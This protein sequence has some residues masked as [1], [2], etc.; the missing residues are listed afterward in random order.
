M[1]NGN[2]V[3]CN[4]KQTEILNRTTG[5]KMLRAPGGAGNSII[6]LHDGRFVRTKNNRLFLLTSELKKIRKTKYTEDVK[7]LYEYKPGVIVVQKDLRG[8]C[9]ISVDTMSLTVANSRIRYLL[10][11]L[12]RHKCGFD[13][14]LTKGGEVQIYEEFKLFRTLPFDLRMGAGVFETGEMTIGYV[15]SDRKMI[16]GNIFT[17]ETLFSWDVDGNHII[18]CIF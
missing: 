14:F 12:L 11:F 18:K 5:R 8:L 13:I 7:V 2:I 4:S 10:K 6:E 17:G 1:K 16:I 15:T 3:Y 9:L